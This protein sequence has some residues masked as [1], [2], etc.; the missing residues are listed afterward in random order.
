MRLAVNFA[1]IPVRKKLKPCI[2]VPFSDSRFNN[3]QKLALSIKN[4]KPKQN[5][6]KIRGSR[7]VL[8]RIKACSQIILGW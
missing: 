5:T 3:V 6:L 1:L 8:L 2:T 4:T 7:F